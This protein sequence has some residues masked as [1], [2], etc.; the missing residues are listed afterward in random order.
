VVDSVIVIAGRSFG[1][2]VGENLRPDLKS[3][4]PHFWIWIKIKIIKIKKLEIVSECKFETRFELLYT[5]SMG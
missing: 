3:P 5:E 1:E 2:G 4:T